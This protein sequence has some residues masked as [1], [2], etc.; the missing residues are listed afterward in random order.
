MKTIFL[1]GDLGLKGP[2]QVTH[3]VLRD[4]G[5]NK[6]WHKAL[7]V[8]GY[9]EVPCSRRLEE[10]FTNRAEKL[11]L[12][13][14]DENDDNPTYSSHIWITKPKVEY[15]GNWYDFIN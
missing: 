10:D 15:A 9:G 14:N 8:P 12:V 2:L 4:R 13:M 5:G 6:H 3:I 1:K 7:I 11:A